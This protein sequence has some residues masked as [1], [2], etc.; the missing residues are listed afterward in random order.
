MF[1]C[2][3]TAIKTRASPT[4]LS[5]NLKTLGEIWVPEESVKSYSAICWTHPILQLHT[6]KKSMLAIMV[7]AGWCV[8]HSGYDE[9]HGSSKLPRLKSS[10]H[11]KTIVVMNKCVCISQSRALPLNTLLRVLLYPVLLL[12]NGQWFSPCAAKINKNNTKKIKNILRG[13]HG[14]HL[15]RLLLQIITLLDV[16]ILTVLQSKFISKIFFFTSQLSQV[17]FKFITQIYH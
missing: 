1:S 12:P 13:K 11:L 5:S 14:S 2:T 7:K 4:K 10:R 16:E 8:D 6:G 15:C 3:C 9:N 17:N